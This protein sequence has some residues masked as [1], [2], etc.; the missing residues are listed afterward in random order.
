MRKSKSFVMFAP[1][2][3]LCEKGK[4]QIDNAAFRSR[5]KAPLETK[6]ARPLQKQAVSHDDHAGWSPRAA[7]SE[8][9]PFTN[10]QNPYSEARGHPCLRR[11]KA[12]L[13]S[14]LP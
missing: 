14:P 4:S 9:P 2:T 1:Q 5:L 7:I 3:C 8:R 11:L 12:K 13:A 6:V 10:L